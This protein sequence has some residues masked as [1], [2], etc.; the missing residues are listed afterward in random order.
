[1]DKN[2]LRELKQSINDTVFPLVL[3]GNGD[4]EE[5]FSVLLNVIRIGNADEAVY[6]QAYEIANKVEDENVKLRLMNELITEIDF[7]LE[8]DNVEE[9]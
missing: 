5:R 2:K 1:M 8:D 9:E 6:Q 7:A 4:P 3:G